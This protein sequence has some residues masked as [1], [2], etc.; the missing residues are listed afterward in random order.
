MK[1]LLSAVL[2]LLLGMVPAAAVASQERVSRISVEHLLWDIPLGIEEEECIALVGELVGV[3]VDGRGGGFVYFSS[4]THEFV[5]CDFPAELMAD[6]NN[7][8]ENLRGMFGVG[9]YL[10]PLEEWEEEWKAFT[11]KH[12]QNL[13]G[14]FEKGQQNY[15]EAMGGIVKIAKDDPEETVWSWDEKRYS[16]PIIDGG[17]DIGMLSDIFEEDARLISVT[18]YFREGVSVGVALSRMQGV[19]KYDFNWEYSEGYDSNLEGYDFNFEVGVA[20]EPKEDVHHM[21]YESGMYPEYPTR[22]DGL[23]METGE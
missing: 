18:Y 3:E 2:V 16:L 14:M 11:A 22:R 15:G 9:F 8:D 7:R 5:I 1:R 17:P 13:L 23:V 6:F 21:L 12:Q 4:P 20:L 19:T 10:V